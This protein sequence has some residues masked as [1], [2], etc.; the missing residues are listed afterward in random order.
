[1]S[2][3]P[4]GRSCRCPFQLYGKKIRKNSLRE[5]DERYLILKSQ[6]HPKCFACLC[7][8]FETAFLKQLLLLLFNAT[9]IN[10]TTELIFCFIK[11]LQAD[12]P[13]KNG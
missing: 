7:F 4:K 12:P 9:T 10:P 3:D 1:M 13:G 8:C 5:Q 2:K 11:A 6:C